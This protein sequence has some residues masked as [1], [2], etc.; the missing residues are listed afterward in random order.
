MQAFLI[1]LKAR[2]SYFLSYNLL[3]ISL[4]QYQLKGVLVN[5]Q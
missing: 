1:Y 5:L 3:R 2:I 4:D